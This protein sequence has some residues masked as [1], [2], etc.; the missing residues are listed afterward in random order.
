[1]SVF[2]PSWNAE[3]VDEGSLMQLVLRLEKCEQQLLAGLMPTIRK[4]P[5]FTVLRI[6]DVYPGIRNF[7][8]PDPNFSIQDPHPKKMFSKLL[9]L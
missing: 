8:I 2:P 1:M 5:L 9:E 6:R 4:V 7:S 3:D